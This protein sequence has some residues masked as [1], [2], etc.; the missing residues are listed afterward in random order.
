[1][2]LR[3]R[4]FEE[5]DAG[6]VRAVLAAAFP[7][8]AEAELVE[9]LRAE[10]DM[11]IEFVAAEDGRMV[12]YVGFSRMKV[13]ADGDRV[14]A[15]ALAPLAVLPTH[16]RRGIARRLV[17]CGLAAANGRGIAIAFVVG[18]PDIYGRFGFRLETAAPFASPYAGPHFMAQWL[19]SPRRPV[20]GNADYAPAFAALP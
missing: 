12:G 18:E 6:D 9:R 20:R 8:A 5:G 11:V 15:L 2:S 16:L 17:E 1:M 14:P 7:S 10:G 4:P 13:D 19:S 3:V